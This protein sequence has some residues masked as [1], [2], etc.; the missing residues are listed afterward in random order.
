M[1]V[2]GSTHSCSCGKVKRKPKEDLIG[3]KFNHL[4]V[5]ALSNKKD[6]ESR[7]LWECKCDC[8]SDELVFATSK[9]LK[10]NRKKSCSCLKNKK[11]KLPIDLSGKTFGKLKV[12]EMDRD[13][14]SEDGQ[15]RWKCECECG[16]VTY[17][18]TR[19][20]KSGSIKSCGCIKFNPNSRYKT[21]EVFKKIKTVWTGMKKRCNNPKYEH[22][23]LYGGRGI[24]VCKEWQSL[25]SFYEW[26]LKNGYEIGLQ[27]DRKDTNGN[28]EPSNCR[29]LTP[30]ENSQ[31]RRNNKYLTIKGEKKLI[32]QWAKEIGITIKTLND[33]IE[34]GWSESEL[35]LNSHERSNVRKYLGKT[36]IINGVEKSFSEWSDI[37]GISQASFRD[38][39]DAGWSD[40]EL[41]KPKGYRRKNVKIIDKLKTVHTL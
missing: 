23:N 25:N 35:L 16:N 5:V 40:D 19:N 31:N 26:A 15:F 27:I 8:G 11:M 13:Y 1:I 17:V 32:S 22:Y 7:F 38:R 9:D 39:V 12:I 41:L 10:C 3:Q 28:Y 6:K 34:R 33:R 37:I 29:W 36:H 4:S 24:V 2:D 21:D 14:Q 30:Q 18:T 20:L